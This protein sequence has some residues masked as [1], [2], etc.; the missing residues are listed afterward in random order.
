MEEFAGERWRRSARRVAGLKIEERAKVTVLTR[1]Y[2][3]QLRVFD[4][5][6]K[7]RGPDTAVRRAAFEQQPFCVDRAVSASC[8]AS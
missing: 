1:L 3:R 6:N 7:R 4:P 2:W 5:D 8:R